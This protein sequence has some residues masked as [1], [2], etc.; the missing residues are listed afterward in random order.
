M[1]VILT[2]EN[3]ADFF[4]DFAHI[5]SDKHLFENR[6]FRKEFHFLCALLAVN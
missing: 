5:R 4:V 3:S 6:L 1:K 2:F